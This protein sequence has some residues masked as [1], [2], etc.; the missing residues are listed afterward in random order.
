M[1]NWPFLCAILFGYVIGSISFGVVIAK[2]FRLGN[3]RN[4]GSGNIGATNVLRT[5]NKLAAFLTLIF[6]TAKGAIAT[7]I[8]FA[9]ASLPS[10]HVLQL[11][12]QNFIELISFFTGC[13]AIFGHNYPLFLNFQGGKGVATT[14]GTI[15]FALPYCALI[16]CVSWIFTASLCRYSSVASL[17][18]FLS[19]PFSYY[20][21]YPDPFVPEIFMGILFLMLLGGYRHRSNIKNLWNGKESKITFKKKS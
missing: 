10:F 13:A 5:G 16:F 2:I 19:L 20:F 21:L 14:F 1:L 3:L 7:G 18:S 17:V 9:M 4:I 6:D 8:V 11:T 15:L 12:H